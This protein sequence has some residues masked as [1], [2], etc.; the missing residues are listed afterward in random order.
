MRQVKNQLRKDVTDKFLNTCLLQQ[1]MLFYAVSDSFLVSEIKKVFQDTVLY[2]LDDYYS[3]LVEEHS[4]HTQV[5]QF[6][7]QVVKSF[8]DL[9]ETCG[10]VDTNFPI[11]LIPD[12]KMEVQP[13]IKQ[14]YTYKKYQ[15]DSFEIAEQ[16]VFLN[17]QY[18]P[19][20]SLYADAGI[21]ASQPR[22]IYTSFGNSAGLDLTMP[23]YDGNKRKIQLKM[24]NISE[25]L[26][27]KYE[28]FYTKVYSSHTILLAK[29][30]NSTDQLL[31]QLKGEA[32]EVNLWMKGNIINEL[33]A[34]TVSINN[35]LLALKKDL[36]VKTDIIQ[37]L[38][39]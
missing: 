21:L 6:Y 14:L 28:Q 24:L 1:Q 19:H 39:G 31:V 32:K 36:E 17:A 18:L 25:N 10:I 37:A 11:L 27:E 26:R 16:A 13:D 9:Y 3:L 4:E 29:Q 35:F 15:V 23:I 7:A 33:E 20:L 22:Y 2:G 12:I 34:G 38:S 8:S 30:I 5:A